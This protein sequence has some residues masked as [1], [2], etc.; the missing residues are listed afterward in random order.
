MHKLETIPGAKPVH[1][2]FYR[3]DPVKK[4]DTERVTHEMLDTDVIQR[5]TSV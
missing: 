3:Q 5:F 1:Q 4:A 2:M